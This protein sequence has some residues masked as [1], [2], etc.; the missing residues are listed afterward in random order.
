MTDSSFYKLQ[1]GNTNDLIVAFSAATV[2]KGKFSFSSVL[3]TS[4]SNVLYLNC[5]HNSWYINKLDEDEADFEYYKN[6]I[7]NVIEKKNITH[8]TFFGGS[9]GAYGALLYGALFN[10][11]VIHCFGLE[12]E[13]FTPHSNSKKYFITK[14]DIIVPDLSHFLASSKFKSLNL[15][16]GERCIVDLYQSS[17]IPAMDRIN[18]YPLRDLTHSI[19]PSLIERFDIA[20]ALDNKDLHSKVLNFFHVGDSINEKKHIIYRVVYKAYVE[21]ESGYSSQ[22][23]INQLKA[24]IANTDSCSLK[25]LCMAY[26]GLLLE[27]TSP[28]KSLELLNNVKSNSP[29]I[30]EIYPSLIRLGRISSIDYSLEISEFALQF[31]KPMQLDL[32]IDILYQHSLNLFRKKKFEEVIE[33]ALEFHRYRKNH[34]HIKYML[35]ISF[36][37]LNDYESALKY[38]PALEVLKETPMYGGLLKQLNGVDE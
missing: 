34:N 14:P 29:H 3:A 35:A 6:I 36:L 26:L 27:R 4:R 19:P 32:Q 20:E 22:L 12:Y 23:T 9:M 18:K 21:L 15:F 24:S 17:L 1:N 38:S 13:L 28:L 37:E 10:A 16:Y 7:K 31:H 25:F 5:P 8:T 33:P 30:S 2:P 11:D